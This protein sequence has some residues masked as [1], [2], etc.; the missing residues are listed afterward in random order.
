VDHDIGL[1]GL[2]YLTIDPPA[3]PEFPAHLILLGHE[4]LIL[5]NIDLRKVEPGL[6]TLHAAPVKLRGV[7]GAWCRAFLTR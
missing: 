7:D 1:V 2:D 6:Y 5:E 4:V 3:E